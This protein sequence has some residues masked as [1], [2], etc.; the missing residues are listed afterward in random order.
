MGILRLVGLI[1]F[2]SHS[3]ILGADKFL[4]PPFVYGSIMLT[5]LLTMK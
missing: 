4:W 5:I 3:V 2:I 1:R